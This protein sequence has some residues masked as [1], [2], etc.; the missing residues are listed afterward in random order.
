MI[1]DDV[2]WASWKLALCGT[3]L[4]V[5]SR[6]SETITQKH[7]C[8][9]RCI[10]ASSG[11]VQKWSVAGGSGTSPQADVTSQEVLLRRLT[12]IV[13]LQSVVFSQRASD[14]SLACEPGSLRTL[15]PH[16][17]LFLKPLHCPSL[18]STYWVICQ[19]LCLYSSL[20]LIKNFYL[21]YRAVCY[22][23]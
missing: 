10:Q 8:V 20:F 21:D 19:P 4:E 3:Q 7:F 22:T 2:T 11:R 9:F 16:S 18:L 17:S 14:N 13:G 23:F 12:A 1:Q 6:L 15:K 5:C